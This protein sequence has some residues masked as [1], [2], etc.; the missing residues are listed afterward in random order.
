MKKIIIMII[1]IGMVGLLVACNNTGNNQSENLT[2][3]EK[4]ILSLEK[5]KSF[6]FFWDLANTNE[7]DNGYGLIPDRYPTNPSIASIASVGFG[8][9]AYVVGADEGWITFEEGYERVDGTLDMLLRL[10][11]IQGF[12]YHFLNT[13]TGTRAWNS[14]ISIIDTGILLMGAIAAGEYFGGETKEKVNEIYNTVNWGWY[15]NN[16]TNR[17]YMGYSPETG[18]SGAWDHIS[19]Q[20]MLYILAAGAQTYS[21]PKTPYT[22]LVDYHVKNYKGT[23]ISEKNP[24]LSV[25]TPFYYTWNG[26]LFQHQFSHAFV[27]FNTYIDPSGINWFENAKL[28]TLANY[29]YTQD[30]SHIYKSYSGK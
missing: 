24:D 22:D 19:E 20:L 12:Y 11:R 23:Y 16:T 27:D 17:F 13:R 18:F 4:E 6:D 3:S 5:R 28:A 8:L 7:Q 26:S 30:F 25:T 15:L 9:A 10:E 1:C 29:A 21:L 2:I 14:E